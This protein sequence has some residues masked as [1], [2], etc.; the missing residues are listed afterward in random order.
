MAKLLIPTRNRPTGLGGVLHFLQKTYP[1]TQVIVADGSADEFKPQNAAAVAEVAPG[2]SVDYRPYAYDMPFFD[3]LLAV[4]RSETD[5]YIVMGSDDDF[6]MMDMLEKGEAYLQSNPDYVTAMGATIH[7]TLRSHDELVAQLSVV[8]NVVSD[9]GEVR[10]RSY[11]AWPFPTTYAVTRREH[12]ISRYEYAAS[13]FIPGFYDYATGLHDAMAGKIRAFPEIGFFGTRNYRHSYLRPEESLIFLRR[14]EQVLT[15]LGTIRQD[16]IDVCGVAE[17]TA[18]TTSEFLLMRRIAELCGVPAHRRAGFFESKIFLNPTVQNQI[19]LFSELFT[20]DMEGR[21]RYLQ[22]MI[23]LVG[24]L[25][26]N[27]QSSDNMGEKLYYESLEAQQANEGGSDGASR[28]KP[29]ARALRPKT[30]EAA[31]KESGDELVKL[32]A[33]DLGSLLELFVDDAASRPSQSAT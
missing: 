12:L 31:G 24:A 14:S 19:T 25:C 8:R 13:R 28:W 30:R 23:D 29:V 10:G 15:L 3:R 27:V 33:V 32:R 7:L 16:L 1:K 22:R 2:L 21:R 9:S 20:E 17:E 6:P 26:A 11:S 5:P 18:K 4:L